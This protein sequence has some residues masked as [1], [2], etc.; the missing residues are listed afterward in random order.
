MILLDLPML[1]RSAATLIK[2]EI[3]QSAKTARWLPSQST[4]LLC[5][6]VL[7]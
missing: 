2:R 3:R 1:L 6:S 7:G 4:L 5:N